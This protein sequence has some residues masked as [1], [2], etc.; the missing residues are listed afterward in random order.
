MLFKVIVDKKPEDCNKCFFFEE[1]L[2]TPIKEGEAI[3]CNIIKECFFSQSDLKFTIDNC[4]MS[5]TLTK[6]TSDDIIFTYEDS[7]EEEN[8]ETIETL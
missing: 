8:N 6:D 7:L 5:E 2:S 4:P 3:I 1:K